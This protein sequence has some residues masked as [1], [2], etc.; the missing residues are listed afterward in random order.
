MGENKSLYLPG[1]N[2]IRAIAAL[3]VVLSHISLNTAQLGFPKN[4][5]IKMAG[6]GVTM[7]FVLSGYLITTLLLKEND[8]TG[9][10]SLR[11]FYMRRI[12]RIWPIYYLVFIVALAWYLFDH[13]PVRADSVFFYSFLMANVPFV[14]GGAIKPIVPLWS[15]GVEEQFYLFWPWLFRWERKLPYL[16]L[17]ILVLL[18]ISKI[19][20]RIFENGQWYSFVRAIEFQSMAIGG[21]GAWAIHKKMKFIQNLYNP[22]LQIVCWSILLIS[23]YQPIH[24]FSIFDGELYAL[25]FLIIIVNVSTNPKAII[26]LDQP[27]MNWLGRISYG[28]Y[29]YHTFV[30]I[31][32]F[33]LLRQRLSTSFGSLL[34]VYLLVIA[35]TLVIAHLSYQYFESWFLSKKE[36]FAVVPSTN[37]KRVKEQSKKIESAKEALI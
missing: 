18:L 21:L 17:G 19:V 12:F 24:I 7:F 9:R 31:I 37:F 14:F 28:I 15:V 27:V 4:E 32:I 26:K 30:I 2:G 23:V 11:K 8:K 33:S 29:V 34:I 13:I 25:I 22:V 1:L 10:V 35:T 5:G 20:L 6:Y 3:L 36:K 16:M